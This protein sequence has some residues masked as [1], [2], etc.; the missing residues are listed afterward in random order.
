TSQNYQQKVPS[1][2]P[3]QYQSNSPQTNSPAQN[4][5]SPQSGNRFQQPQLGNG[6]NSLP[7]FNPTQFFTNLFQGRNMSLPSLQLPQGANPFAS[8]FQSVGVMNAAPS[9]PE[10]ISIHISTQSD[11]TTQSNGPQTG[12]T[13]SVCAF[14]K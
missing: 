6:G 14:A 4:Q 9:Q 3:N 10:L 2:M 1:Q 13:C 7:Q 11:P 5:Q 12:P 8:I